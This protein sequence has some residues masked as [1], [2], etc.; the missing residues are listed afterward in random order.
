MKYQR[1][2][3]E[4]DCGPAC[5]VM[6]VS[7]YRLYVTIG[8]VRE[9]SKTD[10]MGTNLAGMAK[11]AEK[12]GFTAKPMR[13]AVRDATLNERL[14]FPFIVHVKIPQENNTVLDHYAVV[15]AVHKDKIIIWDPDPMRGK[16]SMHRQDFLKV[17]TG[18]TL[19]LSPN[20]QFNP[21]NA[22]RKIFALAA[23]P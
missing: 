19:F 7:H 23:A 11:A 5:I 21:R 20:M 9:I 22:R 6:A 15:K 12:L 1:Q 14:I 8:K 2:M 10:T 13:G 17:W 3:D 4:S 16:R 18:Y